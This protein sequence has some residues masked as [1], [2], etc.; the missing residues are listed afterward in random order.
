MACRDGWIGW[1]DERRARQL[2]LVVNNSRLLLL[3]EMAA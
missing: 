3:P 2:R 1:D